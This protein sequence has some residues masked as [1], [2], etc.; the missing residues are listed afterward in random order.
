MA[1]QQDHEAVDAAGRGGA[2][3]GEGA[4]DNGGGP[5]PVRPGADDRAR[6]TPPVP[7]GD[8]RHPDASPGV[9]L[10]WDGVVWGR[11]GRGDLAWACWD[12]VD[13]DRL[14]PWLAAERGRLLRELALHD[15]ARALEEEG[16]RFAQDLVD[17]VMLRISLAADALGEDRTDASLRVDRAARQ[18]EAARAMLDELPPG[19]RTARQAMRA[20]WVAT[21]VA[22]ARGRRVKGDGLPWQGDDGPGFPPDYAHGSDFHRAKGL[23]VAGVVRGDR[24]SLAR[25]AELAPPALRWAVELARVDAG[26]AGAG[27]RAAAGW[28][29]VRP[30]PGHEEAVAATPVAARLRSLG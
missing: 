8:V 27:E 24:W 4:A 17:V 15:R 5:D 19:P 2:E 3:S 9:S 29:A 14:A 16:L 12:A 28:R 26:E 7:R 6:W 20:T 25:A 18:L 22:L 11:L 13:D 10:A 23:L 30:P 1:E 21:E